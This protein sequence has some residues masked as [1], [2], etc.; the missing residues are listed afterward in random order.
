GRAAGMKA[1]FA[2]LW[3]VISDLALG[4][5]RIAGIASVISA[6]IVI[7][8]GSLM[9]MWDASE[10]L[11]TAVSDGW[12]QIKSAF[13]QGFNSVSS[14]SD[15]TVSVWRQMGD[16]LAGVV[17]FMVMCIKPFAEIFGG[18]VASTIE[19]IGK[20]T[21]S[22]SK[23]PEGAQHYQDLKDKAIT[24]MM[25][26]R[27]TTGDEAEKAKSQTIQAFQEMTNEVIK[28]L[29]GKKGQFELMF[30]QLMGVVPE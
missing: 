17:D 12:E 25:E 4:L 3:M 14:D 18:M 27:T 21:G 20:L 5:L 1:A 11:R 16:A 29:D 24:H 2:A 6:G 9:Q 15:K 23:V 28:E 7:V 10:K 19:G 13:S 22:F 30:A 8:V 26:L